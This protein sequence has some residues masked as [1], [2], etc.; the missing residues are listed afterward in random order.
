[1]LVLERGKLRVAV[2]DGKDLRSPRLEDSLE[3][4]IEKLKHRGLVVDLSRVESTVS[5]GMEL[6]IAAQGIAMI[7]HVRIAFAGVRP[8]VRRLLKSYGA[9]RALAV[10]ETVD[11]ALEVLR[12]R[13]PAATARPTESSAPDG[14]GKGGTHARSER[15]YGSATAASSA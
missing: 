9:E 3:H 11:E 6:L 15:K 8:R 7:Y 13:R 5:C 10:Y 4:L 1:M 12:D 2:I 14:A